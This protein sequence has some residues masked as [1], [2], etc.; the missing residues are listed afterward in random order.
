MRSGKPKKNRSTRDKQLARQRAR[1]EAKRQEYPLYRLQPPFEPY[2]EWIRVPGQARDMIEHPARRDDS[3]PDGAKDLM[4]TLVKL[5]PRYHG[6]VPI[7]AVHLDHQLRQ[8][9]VNVAVTGR[10]DRYHPI[11]LA[12]L[13]AQVSDPEC[14]D[15]MRRQY[16]DAGLPEEVSLVTD[17]AAAWYVHEI[18]THGLV[19]LDDDLLLNMAIPPKKPG[20]RWLLNGHDWEGGTP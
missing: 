5:G 14:L 19:V 20:G 9:A 16:P 2:G 11:P 17:D 4:D 12:E 1:R 13:A 6:I 10:P 18:H 7:A 8:G 3:L 15:D